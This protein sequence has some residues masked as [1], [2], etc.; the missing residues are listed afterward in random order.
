MYVSPEFKTK[1]LSKKQLKMAKL[2]GCTA[3]GH[4]LALEKVGLAWRGLIIQNPIS[5]MQMSGW[6]MGLLRR[7]NEKEEE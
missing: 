7:L 6:R 2:Y 3:L 1:R 5:G 4:S